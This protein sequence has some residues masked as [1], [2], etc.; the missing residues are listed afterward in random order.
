[1]KSVALGSI[2]VDKNRTISSLDATE[3]NLNFMMGIGK[4]LNLKKA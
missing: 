4:Q 3:K 2:D 1:M